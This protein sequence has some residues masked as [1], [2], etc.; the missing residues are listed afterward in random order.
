MRGCIW[1]V[2]SLVLRWLSE[3]KDWSKCEMVAWTKDGRERVDPLG[4]HSA[5]A[6]TVW[7]AGRREPWHGCSGG[8]GGLAA[9]GEGR[10]AEKGRWVGGR[11]RGVVGNS[12]VNLIAGGLLRIRGVGRTASWAAQTVNHSSRLNVVIVRQGRVK[13]RQ[14]RQNV[15]LGRLKGSAVVVVVCRGHRHQTTRCG[16]GCEQGVGPCATIRLIWISGVWFVHALRGLPDMDMARSRRR[17]ACSRGCYYDPD[18]AAAGLRLE[19]TPAVHARPIVRWA[20]DGHHAC[21]GR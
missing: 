9:R 16:C 20:G 5:V 17:R 18:L 11:G 3:M 21:S 19:T 14:R 1:Y 15:G 6:G 2:R 12:G 13:E 8:G 4:S 10:G 7:A